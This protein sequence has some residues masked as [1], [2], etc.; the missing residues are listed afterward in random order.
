MTMAWYPHFM[1]DYESDTTHLSLMEHGAYRLLLDHYYKKRQPLPANASVLHRV[2]RAF[3]SDEQAA[4]QAVLDEFFELREDGY[5]QKRADKEIDKANEISVKR[6][7][8]A[9]VRH[10]KDNKLK[11]ER[12]SQNGSNSPNSG[13]ANAVQV[14]SKSNASAGANALQMDTQL[15]T[16]TN[17]EKDPAIA[18]GSISEQFKDL[19]DFKT[20]GKGNGASF[21][22]K[23]RKEYPIEEVKRAAGLTIAADAE[24]PIAFMRSILDGTGRRPMSQAE[25]NSAANRKLVI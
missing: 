16:H 17:K 25:M 9:N 8:A 21:L 5:H 22:G 6:T 19:V 10:S 24:D 18:A 15:T 3:A 4:V 23:C 12:P 20:R 2:C 11:A 14:H 7:A 13:D 1:S